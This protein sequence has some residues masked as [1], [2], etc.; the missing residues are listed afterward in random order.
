MTEYKTIENLQAILL[1]NSYWSYLMRSMTVQSYMINWAELIPDI[2]D[3]KITPLNW[4]IDTIKCLTNSQA[5]EIFPLCFG[6]AYKSFER[7]PSLMEPFD[8]HQISYDYELFNKCFVECSNSETLPFFIS[9][10]Y[11]PSLEILLRD[12]PISKKRQRYGTQINNL[13]QHLL[14]HGIF[15]LNNCLKKILENE[16]EVSKNLIV[17]KKFLSNFDFS[18]EKHR[19]IYKIFIDFVFDCPVKMLVVLK[20][21]KKNIPY[22]CLTSLI[23]KSAFL[24]EEISTIIEHVIVEDYRIGNEQIIIENI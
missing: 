10:G 11:I 24:D 7:Y 19:D 3:R 5:R 8:C 6:I 14:Q 9:K 21:L 4:C 20:L 12:F 22:G 13:L 17:S 18:L 15:K 16:G 23:S 2:K 1:K